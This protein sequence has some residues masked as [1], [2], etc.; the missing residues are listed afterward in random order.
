[1]AI[2]VNTMGVYPRW[3]IPDE[4]REQLRLAHQLREELVTLQLRYDATLTAIWSSYPQVA[5][6]EKTLQDAEAAAATAAEAVSAKRIRQ[7]TKRVSGAPADQLA[8]ARAQLRPARSARREAI[9]L[10]RAEATDQILAAAAQ[11]RASRK[12]LY[13]QFCQ[14]ND[15]YWATHNDVVNHHLAAVKRIKQTRAA[16][17]RHDR[18][19]ATDAARPTT[20]TP[21][22]HSSWF[23][24]PTLMRRT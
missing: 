3:P 5:A 11:L 23:T 7:R 16:G 15:L 4:V 2:T 6:A 20:R 24:A 18:R 10:V 14:D 1:M 8:A 19:C 13:R 17:S 12:A 22:R 9:N 21:Q